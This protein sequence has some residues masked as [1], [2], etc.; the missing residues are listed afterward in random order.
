MF[1]VNVSKDALLTYRLYI[2]KW[3]DEYERIGKVDERSRCEV[4][5]ATVSP[6]IWVN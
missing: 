4:F 6:V 2:V 5:Q 1:V 3:K